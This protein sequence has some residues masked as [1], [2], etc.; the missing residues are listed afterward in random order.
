MKTLVKL[1]G[2]LLI[3]L[4]VVVLYI[5]TSTGFFRSIENSYTGSVT[6]IT[7]P[8]AEDLAIDREAGF[9]IIS[10][11]DRAGQRDGKPTLNGLYYM[12]LQ[13]DQ[14]KLKPL[15]TGSPDVVNPHGISMLRLDSNSHRL[16][17]VNHL[18]IDDESKGAESKWKHQIDEYILRGQ[19]LT[20][21]KTHT[22]ELMISPNDV[23]AIDKHRFYYTNDHGS[24]TP[25]GLLAEDYLGLARSNVAY[26][27]GTAYTIVADGIAYANGINYDLN[28]Q[29]L[30]VASPRD[31]L[32]KVYQAD[33]E[34]HLEFQTDIDCNSG[35]DNI[36]LDA[37][38]TLWIG[39]HPKL[40]SFSA[41]AGG[42]QPI[43]PSEIITI[44][45]QNKD[46]YTMQSLY[47]SDGSDMSGSTVAIPYQDKV[48]V[49]NVMDEH[50]IILDRS[51]MK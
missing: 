19:E 29:L 2:L 13:D 6:K 35:V 20:H 51:K 7:V 26:Y 44:D 28:R 18:S 50:F 46:D 42:G 33:E 14:H 16:L 45:Y 39:S 48:F 32:I 5:M 15:V 17:V 8:G 36:E 25:L 4:I 47:E 40:L 38:G 12:D 41:Y 11:A 21:I 31:F 24:R 9:M 43:A 10:S 34:G 1:L 27:D 22:D 37:D 49:G 23:V 3:I 30:Y